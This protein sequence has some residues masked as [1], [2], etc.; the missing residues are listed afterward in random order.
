MKHS[1]KKNETTWATYYKMYLGDGMSPY[2]T[3]SIEHD[4]GWCEPKPPEINW[5]AL[6]PQDP[7]TAAAFAEGLLELAEIAARYK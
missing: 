2:A 7:A 3:L 4:G 6:G 1:I 5:S